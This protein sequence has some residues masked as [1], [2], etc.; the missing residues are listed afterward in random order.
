MDATIRD[1]TPADGPRL[2]AIARAA[3]AHWGYPRSWLEIWEKDLTLTPEYLRAHRGFVALRGGLAL[4]LCVLED[5]GEHWAIEHLWVDPSAQR[6]GIGRLLVEHALAVARRLRPG[7]VQVVADP[8]AEPFYIRLGAVHR[9]DIPAPMPEAPQ[10]RLPLL[11][12]S[13]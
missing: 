12:F 10:R 2:S 9:D 6:K 5:R 13:V 3:K 7:R 4:G 1:A 8:L 11:E